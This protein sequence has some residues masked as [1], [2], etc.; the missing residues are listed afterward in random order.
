MEAD[1]TIAAAD[2][3]DDVIFEEVGDATDDVTDP[4][5]DL[6]ENCKFYNLSNDEVSIC[7]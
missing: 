6:D 2:D 7:L 1:D 5:V 3:N 4:F